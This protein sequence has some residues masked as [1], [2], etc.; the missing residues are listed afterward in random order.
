MQNKWWETDTY[1]KKLPNLKLRSQVIY[2]V[3][4]F[5]VSQDFL[6]VETPALQ[7][8]PGLEPHLKAFK[9][10]LE[11]PLAGEGD[12]DNAAGKGAES[13]MYLHTSPEFCM[14][15]LLVA[16][17]PKIFQMAKVFRNG[18]RSNTH[19]PEFTMLE[20]YRAGEDYTTLMD[21]CEGLFKAAAN[22]ANV[23]E[24]TYNGAASSPFEKWERISVAEA[25][26]KYAG[27]D[28]FATIAK[29]DDADPNPDAFIAEARRIGIN[30][31]D[32]DR[33]DDVFFKVFLELI[34][35]KLGFG[36]PTILYDYPIC[37]AALSR[38]KPTN[39]RIAERFEV[40]VCG[41]E[42]ANAFSELTDADVQQQRFEADMDL[43]E[44]LY[45]ERYPIDA[46]FIDALRHGMPECTGIALGIDR[47][48]MLAVGAD[49]I[50]DTLWAPVSG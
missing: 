8:S 10:K 38:A 37:M 18:E 11:H 44:K 16:G 32:D 6:E 5:F 29:G 15:K 43:K 33:W 42:L 40:Y 49:N 48:V 34:E 9:T 41:M 45:G 46:D 19:H 25:F 30:A 27:L 4:D 13:D 35:P 47:L 17:L 14:K 50:E 1:L 21:D 39:P 12:L 2:A 23:R 20:W 24:F 26:D 36:A 22:A 7:I 28:L 31:S 3:R